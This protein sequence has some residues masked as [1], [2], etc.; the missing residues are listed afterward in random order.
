MAITGLTRA[1]ARAADMNLR[2]L[3][4]RLEIHDDRA[5]LARRRP[6]GRDSRRRRRRPCRRARRC[7]R[8]RH[9]CRPPSRP[10]TWRW[11]PI[12]TASAMLPGFAAICAKLAL[13]LIGGIISA[14][15]VRA[16]DAEQIGPR[17][18]EHRLAQAVLARQA[19]RDDDGRPCALLA[20]LADDARAPLA[21]GVTMTARSGTPGSPPA[22]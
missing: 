14:E 10:A 9:C 16:D 5:R 1:A 15:R 19:G 18:I 4:M 3:G 17:R 21:G 8:S 22:L 13:S 20:E 11:R 7:E 2:A 12:A 6:A